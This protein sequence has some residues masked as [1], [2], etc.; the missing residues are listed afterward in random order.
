MKELDQHLKKDEEVKLHAKKNQQ[1]ETQ[2]V[3]I[4]EIQQEN[5]HTL[6]EINTK[7]LTISKAVFQTKNVSFTK[8]AVGDYSG[9][10]DLVTNEDCVYIP[11]LNEKNAWKKFNRDQRQESYYKKKAP[12]Q[13][14]SITTYK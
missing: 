6:F 1:K 13:L 8:A 5:G 4:G 9:L 7:S 3:L 12:M 2:K 11:A 10:N 14:D